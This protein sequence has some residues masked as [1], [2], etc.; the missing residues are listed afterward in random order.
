MKLPDIEGKYR[1]LLILL[2]ISLICLFISLWPTFYG[3]A[4]PNLELGGIMLYGLQFALPIPMFFISLI[5]YKA[6]ERLL[7]LYRLHLILIIIIPLILIA[8]ATQTLTVFV[9]WYTQTK[10]NQAFQSFSVKVSILSEKVNLVNNVVGNPEYPGSNPYLYNY[11]YKIEINNLTNKTFENIPLRISLG[12]DAPE[13]PQSWDQI[14][15]DSEN[16]ILITLK[17]GSNVLNGQFPVIFF[18][19]VDKK[20]PLQNPVL[21]EV[22]AKIDNM[23]TIKS[24]KTRSSLDWV[25][26]YTAQQKF[27]NKNKTK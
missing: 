16:N 18:D 17:P 23:G 4:H 22:Y 19:Q 5:A 26:I 9:P 13:Q 7:N 20:N 6:T 1:A 25:N 2:V 11:E 15:L 8:P 3:L 12:F 10:V 24:L 27:F 21:L 14:S